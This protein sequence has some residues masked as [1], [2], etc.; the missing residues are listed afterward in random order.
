MRRLIDLPPGEGEQDQ[1]R[2]DRHP[3]HRHKVVVDFQSAQDEGRQPD[4]QLQ[5][6]ITGKAPEAA[7]E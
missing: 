3:D 6:E 7:G 1:R 5:R 4:H 2:F